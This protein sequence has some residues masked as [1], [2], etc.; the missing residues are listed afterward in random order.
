[1]GLCRCLRLWLFI[2]EKLKKGSLILGVVAVS[3][4]QSLGESVSAGL[5]DCEVDYFFGDNDEQTPV[6][7]LSTSTI[8]W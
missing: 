8:F 7:T 5:R 3:R 4:R 6:N 1:M 2:F